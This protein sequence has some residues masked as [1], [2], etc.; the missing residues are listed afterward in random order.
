MNI[1]TFR[2]LKI[3]LIEAINEEESKLLNKIK[4]ERGFCA[5]QDFTLLKS[6]EKRAGT[7]ATRRQ[8]N[9][10]KLAIEM[11][12]HVVIT[13]QGDRNK[14]KKWLP[15]HN[16][17]SC[18]RIEF[19]VLRFISILF[20]LHSQLLLCFF[21]V[22]VRRSTF[23]DAAA[24]QRENE[25]R[26]GFVVDLHCTYFPSQIYVCIPNWV[27]AMLFES[28]CYFHDEKRFLSLFRPADDDEEFIQH[29]KHCIAITMSAHT[30]KKIM[31][32][33]IYSAIDCFRNPFELRA[34]VMRIRRACLPRDSHRFPFN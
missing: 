17:I 19:I 20:L 27:N 32:R 22:V 24:F 4:S 7:G 11:Q 6:S 31:N 13:V 2:C 28:N 21:C 5:S 23:R 16:P 25:E 18:I 3:M 34:H 30:S 9:L 1:Y 12:S 15:Q 10:W 26:N 33:G 14:V 8:K 29:L